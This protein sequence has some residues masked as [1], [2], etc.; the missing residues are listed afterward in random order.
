MVQEAGG[1]GPLEDRLDEIQQQLDMQTEEGQRRL[2]ETWG[3]TPREVE[4][5]HLAESMFGPK[6]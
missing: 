5:A 3:T 6:G 2:R 4:A 1:V